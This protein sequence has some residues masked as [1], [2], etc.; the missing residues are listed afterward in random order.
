VKRAMIGTIMMVMVAG[1]GSVGMAK[2]YMPARDKQLIEELLKR[3]KERKDLK[4]VREDKTYGPKE[5]AWYLKYKWDHNKEKVHSVEDFINLS[6]YGG[7]HGEITYYVKFSDGTVR[8]AKEVL[9][10]SVKQLEAEG[11]Q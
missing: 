6:S 5:A 9:E 11:Q 1:M 10:E 2:D 4:F 7:D 3:L 8:P